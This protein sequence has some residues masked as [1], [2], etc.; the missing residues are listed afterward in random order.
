MRE[1]LELAAGGSQVRIHINPADHQ[2]LRPQ[3]EML[4]RETSGVGTAELIADPEVTSGG[5][6]VETR[7][8]VI[9]QQLEAQLARIEEELT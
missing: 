8:G 7:F 5:C 6:R 4:V 9:D 2:T 3:I 1:A